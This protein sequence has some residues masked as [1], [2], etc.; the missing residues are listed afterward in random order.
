MYNDTITA[1][2]GAARKKADLL[3]SSVFKYLISSAFAGIFIGLGVLLIFTIG[4]SLDASG[5]PM[6]KFMM[7]IS[8]AIALSLVILTGTDLFTG[9]NL[10]MTMG[11]MEKSVSWLELI[12]VWVVSYIGNLLGAIFL[13]AIYVY[14]GLVTKGPVMDF[15]HKISIAKASAPFSELFFRGILCNM[16]VCL[17]VL[18]CF[19][20][21]NDAAKLMII[22]L[23]LFAFISSGF[24]HSIANMTVYAVALISPVITDV[25][26]DAAVANLVPVTLGNIIGGSIVIGLGFYC[27]KGKKA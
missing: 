2:A 18:I 22:F 3:N 20:T 11:A 27:L 12:K 26:F 24:E 7:G 23:C 15:F 16:L 19:R 4:G 13:G 10:V 9:N 25:G 6:I 17:A 8:F 21:A 1:I 5:S 14:T